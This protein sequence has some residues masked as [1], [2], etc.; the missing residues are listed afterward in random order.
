M[1]QEQEQSHAPAPPCALAVPGRKTPVCFSSAPR[2]TLHTPFPRGTVVAP[3]KKRVAIRVLPR[4]QAVGRYRYIG[5]RAATLSGNV[6]KKRVVTPGV[7]IV[8]SETRCIYCALGN[9]RYPHLDLVR[10]QLPQQESLGPT[11]STSGPRVHVVPHDGTHHRLP[12]TSSD[13]SS[14]AYSPLVRRAYGKQHRV[15]PRA[16]E[17]T[18]RHHS[19]AVSAPPLS[20]SLEAA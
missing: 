7:Y 10:V 4:C 9:T 5:S 13:I 20:P 11:A 8:P 18:A 6:L 1:E 12:P 16:T 14:S 2:G 15:L 17:T 3:A 19:V